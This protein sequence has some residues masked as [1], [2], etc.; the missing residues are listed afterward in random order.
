MGEA[1]RHEHDI[2]ETTCWGE[3]AY[4]FQAADKLRD[5]A[6]ACLKSI[7]GWRNGK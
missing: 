4:H 5:E 3:K 1:M 6:N 7:P 2:A